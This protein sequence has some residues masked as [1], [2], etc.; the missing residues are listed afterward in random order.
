MAVLSGASSPA[1]VAPGDTF[2]FPTSFAQQRLWFLDRL[3]PA[4]SVYNIPLSMRLEGPLNI[5]ALQAAFNDIVKRHEI[6]RT[7]FALEQN[8]PC[9]VVHPFV[10][11]TLPVTALEN[12]SDVQD[13]IYSR[14]REGGRRGFDLERGPLWRAELL[15]VSDTQFVLLMTVHH[16]VFDGWSREIFFQELAVLYGEYA[17]NQLAV[18]PEL[19]I[20]YADYA[21]WQREWLQGAALESELEYWKQTLAGAPCL[22]ELP[23]DHPR[24]A[25]QTYCGGRQAFSISRETADALD[26]FSR[27]VRASLF[28]TLLAAFQVLLYRQT[29]QSD[30]L[31]GTPIANRDRQALERLIGFFVNTLVMRGR[32][33]DELPFQEFLAQVRD[34]ALDAYAH[35]NLPFEKLVEAL[36]PARTLAYPP[37]IQVAL[38][39]V[40]TRAS[41]LRLGDVR[42]EWAAG[43]SDT[44]KFDLMLNVTRNGD[45]LYGNAEYSTDLF[46]RATMQRLVS[47][48]QVL[49]EGI[50][51]APETP[52]G[53]L[54]LL[55]HAEQHEM[56]VSWNATTTG[57]PQQCVHESFEAQVARTPHAVAVIHDSHHLTFEQVN[58]RAN[59]LARHLQSLGVATET[60]VGVM[61]ERSSDLIIALLAILKA[62]G[63]YLPL[64]PAYPRA[65]LRQ[66]MD[67]VQPRAIITVTT[68]LD[69]LPATHAARVC[70]D[71][72]AASIA[73]ASPGNLRLSLSP[74]NLIYLLYTSGSTGQP[75]GVMGL[76]RGAVNRIMWMGQQ[77]PFAPGE[78]CCQ[79]TSLN[80]V[81]SVAEIFGPLLYGVPVVLLSEETI[82]DPQLLLA[83]L[84]KH[85]V[86]RIT[87][88]PSLLRALCHSLQIGGLP[89]LKLWLCSGEVLDAGLAH[90]FLQY[91]PH[92]RLVNLYGC[93]EV[94]A[95][96]TFFEI[97][98]DWAGVRV[99]IGRPIANTQIYLLN[100]A[101]EPAP[102]GVTGELYIGGEGVARG[103]F[104]QPG[105]TARAF[106]PN[107]YSSLVPHCPTLYR[108]GDLARYLPRG[109]IEYMG[110]ADQQIKVRGM[111]VEPG[112]VEAVVRAHPKVQDAAVVAHE[113]E[114]DT[115]LAAYVVGDLPKQ[116][117]HSYLQG[118]LPA[119]MVPSNFIA[120]TE[121]PRT[122]SGKVDRTALPLPSDRAESTGSD[123]HA[124]DELESALQ[125]IWQRLLRVE[126]IGVTDNFFDLGGHSLSAIGLFGEIKRVLG[127]ELPVATLF[128]APTIEKL[129]EALRREST[130]HEWTP[131]IAIQPH[132]TR[133]PFFCVH[134]FGGGVVG[135]GQ[136]ARLLDAEQP[137]YGLEARGQTEDAEPDSTIEAMASRYVTAIR[138]K[139]RRGPYYLGGYCYGGTV[140]FEMARQLEARGEAV[141]FL[142]VFEDPA[143]KSGYR[144]F[145]LNASTTRGFLI[146]L[147]Y[148]A[149]DY[150]Q[151]DWRHKWRRVERELKQR[152]YHRRMLSTSPELDISQVELRDVLDDV[153][154]IPQRHQRL[155]QVHIAAMVRYQPK[156]YR[157][158]VTVFR[159]RRQP[160][161][162]SHDPF[163]GWRELAPEVEV[164]LVQGSHHNLL[165]VPY[166]ESLAHALSRYLASGPRST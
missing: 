166:V 46:E 24:P 62:G 133:P 162:C 87:L 14:V 141:A 8:E 68:H 77:Y 107:P 118:R 1:P 134:G 106:I 82:R 150:I 163:L 51:N 88:V 145:R 120:L 63:A 60:P 5:P 148:W 61:L 115:R 119:H 64:D 135:Y 102:I 43:D 101:L 22:L 164:H 147:P 159:T 104:N 132:G 69:K 38:N 71:R 49:L 70:L 55:T 156:P 19:P 152:A 11:I 28:M 50:T 7:T 154:P 42:A 94:A 29:G 93:T 92:A 100:A 72:D 97:P 124:R 21:V 86:T 56:L 48:F 52:V 32:L 137:F 6:L 129:A 34:T 139:Q 155:I 151:L 105:L 131:L 35:Q 65:R 75:K 3:E 103:Y 79:K 25:I 130:M 67:Q 47:Q 89:D 114:K 31:V 153:A 10:P 39:Y 81:D 136:L 112:E 121:L 110:R 66:M 111:R 59:Q 26:A 53:K 138:K 146:N 20:Q 80:F 127:R 37:L 84:A 98:G 16:I 85:R 109:M 128:Q 96:S 149:E 90:K 157:G 91:V 57:K 83:A 165:E 44:A 95:D 142:G 2:I 9:Q 160:L 15:R 122:P 76:H 73:R 161:L 144:R 158:R 74:D 125:A 4:S 143:P 36:R 41:M 108:T 40:Q 58:V 113:S 117:M 30:I 99:P 23:R 13:T 123:V 54:P 140:A 17:R 45:G 33:Y 27:R 116:E 126:R 12:R 78:V 18:L